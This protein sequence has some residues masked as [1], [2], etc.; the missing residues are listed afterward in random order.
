MILDSYLKVATAQAFTDADEVSASSVDL[1]A[2]TIK[3]RVGTGEDLC[4]IFQITT[5]AAGD[6]ASATDTCRLKIV[7]DTQS[8]LAT[9]TEV[10]SRLIP[11]ASLTANSLWEVPMPKGSPTKR[12]IGAQVE[13]GTGDT[14]SASAW[15]VPRDHVQ[16]FLAYAKGY[17]I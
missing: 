3:N 1:G 12:Y 7:E 15:F 8:S 9:K 5:A 13:L 2:P 11:A 16:D 17:A 4:C 14:L 6:S 10:I